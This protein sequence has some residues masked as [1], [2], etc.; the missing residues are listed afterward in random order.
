[1]TPSRCPVSDLL[2]NLLQTSQGGIYGELYQMEMIYFF[3]DSTAKEVLH[4]LCNAPGCH[5]LLL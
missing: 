3:L 2:L 5:M 1:M 4:E